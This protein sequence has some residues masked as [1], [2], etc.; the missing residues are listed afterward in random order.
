[1]EGIND[2]ETFDED[3][4]WSAALNFILK[5]HSYCFEMKQ[6]VLVFGVTSSNENVYAYRSIL[7]D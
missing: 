6:F 3:V 7:G 5:H 4:I 1:M 2:G